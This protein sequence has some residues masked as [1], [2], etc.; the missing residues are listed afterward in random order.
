[1]IEQR[2]EYAAKQHKFP[3]GVLRSNADL[4]VCVWNNGV[5]LGF[6][7]DLNVD[8]GKW[9]QLTSIEWGAS[10]KIAHGLN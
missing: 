7:N 1:M 3:H 2:D 6:V 9:E 4:L 8:N 10:I 5:K